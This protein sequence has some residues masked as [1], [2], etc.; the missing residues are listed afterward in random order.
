MD[1]SEPLLPT[2]CYICFEECSESSPCECKAVVH[3]SCLDEFNQKS[4]QRKCTICQYPLKRN[5]CPSICGKVCKVFLCLSLTSVMVMFGIFIYIMSG[6]LGEYTWT[7]L[8]LCEC[9]KLSNTFIGTIS[10]P[11]FAWCSLTMLCVLC[12]LSWCLGKCLVQRY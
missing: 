8:G 6:F 10:T 5:M 4:R 3:H 11:V 12:V 9:D 1:S 2:T 7:T